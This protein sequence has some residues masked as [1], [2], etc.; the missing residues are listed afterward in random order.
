MNQYNTATLHFLK[1]CGRVLV[2]VLDTGNGVIRFS[3]NLQIQV[4]FDRAKKISMNKSCS[5]RNFKIHLNF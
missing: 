2:L 5:K 1:L 4:A 3:L